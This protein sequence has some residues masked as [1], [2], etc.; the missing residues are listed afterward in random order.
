VAEQDC[1]PGVFEHD[2]RVSEVIMGGERIRYTWEVPA[3]IDA[4]DVR[5]L[6]CQLQGVTSPLAAGYPGDES[7]LA[8]EFSHVVLP[9]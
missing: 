5:A 9:H 6:F 2:F 4:D 3:K 1:T 7:Y 8:I